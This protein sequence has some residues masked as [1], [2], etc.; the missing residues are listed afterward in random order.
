VCT[1][2]L[3]QNLPNV[4]AAFGDGRGRSRADSLLGNLQTKIFHG[5]GDAV[6]NEWA[7]KMIA[8]VWQSRTTVTGGSSLG[9]QGETENSGFSAAE[10]LAAQVLPVEFTTLAKGGPQ[11]A[12]IVEGI[13]FQSG[14]VWN[15]SRS[16]W[17]RTYFPQQ[18]EGT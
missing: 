12:F 9:R 15:A 6:T 3:T 10:Q 1:V 11:N 13:V 8:Q 5:N 2:Y 17:L 18:L 14:R 7:S 4:Y 16:N